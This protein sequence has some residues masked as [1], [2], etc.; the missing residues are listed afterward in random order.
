MALKERLKQGW[1][2]CIIVVEILGK[3]KEYVS[4]VIEEVANAI[5][6]A[7]GI[8][9]VKKKMHEPKEANN[10]LFSTF[11]EIEMAIKDLKT[12]SELVFAYMPSNIEILAPLGQSICWRVID[13]RQ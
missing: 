11:T 1:I 10:G 2:H 8:D 6:R 7:P 13:Y 4:E 12:L 9:L 3:P 5:G